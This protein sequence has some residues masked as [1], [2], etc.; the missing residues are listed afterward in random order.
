MDARFRSQ[1]GE[2]AFPRAV[3]TSEANVNLL[4]SNSIFRCNVHTYHLNK[5][6]ESLIA[7]PLMHESASTSVPFHQMITNHLKKAIIT[8]KRRGAWFALDRREKSLIYLAI[9]LNVSYRS[10]DLLRALTSVLKK[11]EQQGET[12]YSWLQRGTRLA[13]VFSGFAVRCGNASAAAWRNDRSY[14]LYL[15]AVFSKGAFWRP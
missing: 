5:K 11:L 14:A 13:W 2:P 1:V 9:R 7:A 10:L 3:E 4:G 6:F 15:G 12:I 8:S